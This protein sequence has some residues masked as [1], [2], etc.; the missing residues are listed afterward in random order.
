MWPTIFFCN[1]FDKNNF[2]KW[3]KVQYIIKGQCISIP[4]LAFLSF[5]SMLIL[6][7]MSPCVWKDTGLWEKVASCCDVW[8]NLSHFAP[9]STPTGYKGT[10]KHLQLVRAILLTVTIQMKCKHPPDS[11]C[12]ICGFLPVKQYKRRQTS[13]VKKSYHLYFGIKAGDQDNKRAHI[14]CVACISPISA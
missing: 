10:L 13:H 14:W 5:W 6:D 8:R 11:F 3:F 4:F 1:G 7:I 2:L 9:R 12:Y